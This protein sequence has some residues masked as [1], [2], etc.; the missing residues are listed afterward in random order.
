MVKIFHVTEFVSFRYIITKLSTA[1]TNFKIRMNTST[2]IKRLSKMCVDLAVCYLV[3]NVGINSFCLYCICICI[4]VH[5]C[6]YYH[7]SFMHVNCPKVMSLER[8]GGEE[9]TETVRN[10]G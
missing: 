10:D 2:Y 1:G 6:I 9:V 4:C 5:I 3:S 7:P 8:T